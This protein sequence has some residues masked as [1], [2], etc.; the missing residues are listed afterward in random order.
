MFILVNLLDYGS[1]ALRNFAQKSLSLYTNLQLRT[2]YTI[3][4]VHEYTKYINS[5][6]STVVPV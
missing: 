2:Y 3:I 1:K 4:I 5:R 6:F